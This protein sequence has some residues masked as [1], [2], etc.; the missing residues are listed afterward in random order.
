MALAA[1]PALASFLGSIFTALV[2][3][4][5]AYLTKRLALVA[6]G[7]VAIAGAFTVFYAAVLALVAGL[8]VPFPV[9]GNAVYCF[10]PA[11]T[12]AC[13]SAILTAYVLRWVYEWKVR[14]IQY[15]FN[16]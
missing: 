9:V 6:A 14:V 8:S 3:F 11:N 10:L 12:Q 4:F 13:V 7:V 5:S 1:I 2:G 15:Q 16:F